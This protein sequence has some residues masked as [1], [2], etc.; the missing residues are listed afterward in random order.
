M[1]WEKEKWL[2]IELML[3]RLVKKPNEGSQLFENNAF[4]NGF[5]KSHDPLTILDTM[6]SLQGIS[7]PATQPAQAVRYT[8]LTWIVWQL[9][10][11]GHTE[12]IVEY[13]KKAFRLSVYYPTMKF[14]VLDCALKCSSH[15]REDGREIFEVR[16]LW[17]CFK[18][19]A[20]LDDPHWTDTEN[21]LNWW[22]DVWCNYLQHDHTNPAES[23]S[24]HRGLTT[25][26]IVNRAC[27]VTFICTNTTVEMV[28]RFWQDAIETG[29]INPSEKY[30]VTA[31]YLSVCKEAAF[32]RH[33]RKTSSSFWKAVQTGI[34]PLAWKTVIRFVFNFKY[35][36]TGVK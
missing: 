17:S 31:L 16:A 18:E 10:S 19:A 32:G 13:L 26:E 5:H 7:N 15:C 22:L 3:C 8:T 9:Y 14:T 24:A 11:T 1:S 2:P 12:Y 6:L 25:Q 33:W 36:F 28:A 34:H 21:A 30:Q 35:P 23:L 29:L 4:C 20:Q 27:P